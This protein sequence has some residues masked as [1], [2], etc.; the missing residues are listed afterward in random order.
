MRAAYAHM[1][2]GVSDM[3]IDRR[4][5]AGSLESS[6]IFVEVAPA[7]GYSLELQ[8]SV[9]QQF[10]EEIER[11]IGEVAQTLGAENVHIRAN[12]H[13]ALECVIRARVET[14]L[15]RASGEVQA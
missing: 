1:N 8:S 10:G 2:K 9:L 13:G 5:V 14:A 15:R 6:D 11:V 4:A 3:K 12:D 7:E